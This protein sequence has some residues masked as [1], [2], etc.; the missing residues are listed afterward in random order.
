MKKI[1]TWIATVSRCNLRLLTLVQI[2]KIALLTFPASPVTLNFTLSRPASL[3]PQ[4]CRRPPPHQ[5]PAAAPPR[6]VHAQAQAG[7]GG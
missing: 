7:A 2:G 5:C 1:K 4:V 6:Q 3:Y